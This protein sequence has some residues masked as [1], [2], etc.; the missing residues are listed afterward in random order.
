MCTYTL[1]NKSLQVWKFV[2]VKIKKQDLCSVENIIMQV[3]TG[4]CCAST[5]SLMS[6]DC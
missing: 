5:A 3:T 2:A 4:M 1:K 6:Y